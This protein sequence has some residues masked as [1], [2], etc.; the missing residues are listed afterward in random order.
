MPEVGWLSVVKTTFDLFHNFNLLVERREFA[1][2]FYFLS[3]FDTKIKKITL[4]HIINKN[5]VIYKRGS[6][7]RGGENGDCMFSR[8]HLPASWEVT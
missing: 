2:Y 3:F 8:D 1:V 7:G 4:K 5:S 6:G